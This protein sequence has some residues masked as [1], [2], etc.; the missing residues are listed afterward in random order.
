MFLTFTKSFPPTIEGWWV[1]IVMVD[2]LIHPPKGV[3]V[4]YW[5][6]FLECPT[7]PV[8]MRRRSAA[9]FA[10]CRERKKS[11]PLPPAREGEGRNMRRRKRSRE[12]G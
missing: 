8:K 9:K 11:D 7:C 5:H 2:N 12:C 3:I 1:A 6:Q 10:K 4:Q